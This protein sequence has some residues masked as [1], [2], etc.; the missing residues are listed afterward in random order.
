MSSPFNFEILLDKNE[1]F[2]ETLNEE[3][4][5]E[6]IQKHTVAQEI[7]NNTNIQE[8]KEK[9][10]V[11]IYFQTT[12]IFKKGKKLGL[13][14]KNFNN[15]VIVSKCD[16]GSLSNEIFLVGD[17]IC[18]VEDVPVLDK[19][20]CRK[21]IVDY[22]QNNKKVTFLV[23][24]LNQEKYNFDK[25]NNAENDE[26]SFCMSSD[27]KEI[28]ALE[29]QR[30]KTYEKPAKSILYK[31]STDYSKGVTF[32]DYVHNYYIFSDYEGKELKSVKK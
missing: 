23:K 16:E 13:C 9:N 25:L 6:Q 31:G 19:D 3:M 26:P 12:L 15:S 2:G 11:N 28:A 29:R 7:L 4:I 1:P 22:I 14:V 32:E 5:V 17:I 18:N 30:I 24:R 27:V 20:I 10:D 8:R 21:L